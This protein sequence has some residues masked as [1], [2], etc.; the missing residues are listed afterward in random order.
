MADAITSALEPGEALLWRGQPQSSPRPVGRSALVRVMALFGAV[1]A[2][3]ASA[4]AIYALVAALRHGE[5]FESPLLF[6][7][8]LITLSLLAACIRFAVRPP[9]E[10]DEDSRT[11]Y[12][13]TSRRVIV[14]MEQNPPSLRALPIDG[15][16]EFD[17]ALYDERLGTIMFRVARDT[18]FALEPVMFERLSDTAT[19]IALIRTVQEGNL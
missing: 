5:H 2:A 18:S 4:L 6:M 9:L 7:L 8:A 14:A 13:V 3:L 11:H 15:S 10:D 1:I 19:P 16:L 17:E 12:A